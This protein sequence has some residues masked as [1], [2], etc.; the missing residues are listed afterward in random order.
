MK[1]N[2]IH[3]QKPMEL[4]VASEEAFEL[5]EVTTCGLNPKAKRL[6]TVPLANF[7]AG[8][9]LTRNDEYQDALASG[10]EVA[11]LGR[12]CYDP[13]NG[14][15]LSIDGLMRGSIYISALAEDGT[16]SVARLTIEGMDGQISIE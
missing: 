12:F 11:V 10:D 5:Y 7:G 14:S 2:A 15:S 6:E 16:V 8:I 1:T 9:R 4:R 13:L 3:T